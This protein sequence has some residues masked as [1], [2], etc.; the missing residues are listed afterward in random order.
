MFSNQA[1]TGDF[2]N[3]LK[4]SGETRLPGTT[5][6]HSQLHPVESNYIPVAIDTSFTS[7]SK[8]FF[9]PFWPKLI[10]GK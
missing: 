9:C 8:A 4:V 5:H 2:F 3:F 7:H 10:S 6:S 1:R